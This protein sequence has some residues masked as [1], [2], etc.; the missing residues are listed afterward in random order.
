MIK[1]TTTVLIFLAVTA[2]GCG[3]V[4]ERDQAATDGGAASGPVNVQ[5]EGADA[6]QSI[7]SDRLSDK[8]RTGFCSADALEVVT[9]EE[10]SGDL[11]AIADELQWPE[12]WATTRGTVSFD[13]AF[14]DLFDRADISAGIDKLYLPDRLDVPALEHPPEVTIDQVAALHRGASL[15]AEFFASPTTLER[16]GAIPPEETDEIILGLFWNG[17][18]QAWGISSAW[19]VDGGEVWNVDNCGL[20]SSDQLRAFRDQVYPGADLATVL[21]AA[22][23]AVADE[24]SYGPP[25]GDEPVDL[26]DATT[27]GSGGLELAIRVNGDLGDGYL[28]LSQSDDSFCALLEARAG[29]PFEFTLSVEPDVEI[30]AYRTNDLVTE[31]PGRGTPIAPDSGSAE[32]Q[33]QANGNLEVVDWKPERPDLDL[34]HDENE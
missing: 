8:D 7:E 1:R 11:T 14:D 28:C 22:P 25:D 32:I 26:G 6:G 16:L 30:Q 27:L 9:D 24:F 17:S 2:S 15:S 19:Q 23:F 21:L 13:G 18:V 10:L 33:V 31:G 4:A 3:S 34:P 5:I 29:E 20:I 12:V